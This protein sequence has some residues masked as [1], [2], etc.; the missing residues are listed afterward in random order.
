MRNKI[1]ALLLLL[2]ILSGCKITGST[3][4]ETEIPDRIQ[5]EAKALQFLYDHTQNKEV[6]DKELS[7][8]NY[9]FDSWKEGDEWHVIIYLG[10]TFIE[11]LVYDDENI[12]VLQET[13]YWRKVPKD[14]KT[15][16]YEDMNKGTDVEFT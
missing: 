2:V 5:A 13:D 16:V 6:Y 11:V 7:L 14:V 8:E 1:I 4:E 15:K 12:K 10:H 3:V 9:V